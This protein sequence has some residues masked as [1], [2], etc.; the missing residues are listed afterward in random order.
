MRAVLEIFDVVS[1][2]ESNEEFEISPE[3]RSNLL[4]LQ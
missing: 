4:V 1:S 3:L 2:S